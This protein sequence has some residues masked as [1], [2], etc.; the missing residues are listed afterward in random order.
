MST[1]VYE[2]VDTTS[3]ETNYSVG[4]FSDR[5]CA[6]A[7]LGS[8]YFPLGEHGDCDFHTY[9]IRERELNKSGWSEVGRVV[10]KYNMVER[11]DERLDES[12]WILEEVK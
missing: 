4:I 1:Y 12:F 2:L 10:A 9:E 6:I 7:H 3:D 11:F 5:D 8:P